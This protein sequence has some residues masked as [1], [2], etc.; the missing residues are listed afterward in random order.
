[1]LFPGA[2]GLILGN[3]RQRPPDTRGPSG[4][5]V[6][7]LRRADDWR[8]TEIVE[9]WHCLLQDHPDVYRLH[10][11]LEWFEHKHKTRPDEQFLLACVRDDRQRVIGLCPLMTQPL[12]LAVYAK[13][14]RVWRTSLRTR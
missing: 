13:A 3:L 9:K 2:R 4:W 10:Q 8:Q 5:S 6:S 14:R 11:S 7:F 1:M 12:D